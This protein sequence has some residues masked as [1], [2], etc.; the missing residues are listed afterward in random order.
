ME[1]RF[2][3]NT[4]GGKIDWGDYLDTDDLDFILKDSAVREVEEE[5]A[6]LIKLAP[7]DLTEYVDIE[8]TLLKFP[9]TK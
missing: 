7:M 6:G 4:I 5:T 9:I 3:W 1:K 2:N 8:P